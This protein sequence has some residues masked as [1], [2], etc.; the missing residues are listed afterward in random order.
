MKTIFL[1]PSWKHNLSVSDLTRYPPK[2]YSFTVDN[3]RERTLFQL[4]SKVNWTYSLQDLV[5]RKLPLMLIKSYLEKVRKIPQGTDLTYA[6]IHLVL[7]R[8]PWILDMQCEPPHLLLGNGWTEKQMSSYRDMVRT[9]LTSSDCKKII[10]WLEAG[11]KA[12]V[13][14]LGDEL[15]EKIEVVYWGVPGKSFVKNYDDRKIKLLFVNSGNINTAT[16]FNIKGGSEVLKAFVELDKR[17]N[18]LELVIRSGLPESIRRQY[19]NCSNIRIMSKPVPW[20]ELEYEW[21]TADIFV[22]PTR[23]P[24]AKVFLDAMCYELPIVTTDVWGNHEL[25]SDG[26]TGL[27]VHYSEAFKYIKNNM[28][29]FHSGYRDVLRKPDSELV[30]GMVDK[31]DVLI[32]NRELRR[33]LGKAG[34]REI[35]TGKFS[36]LKRNENL[37]KIFDEATS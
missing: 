29:Y 8:E 25:V 15:G 10:C 22:F 3:G 17:Y 2:G 7:R 23:V 36:L 31:I 32:Q 33:S 12:L 34:R 28:L 13:S 14:W 30:D 11:K 27:L 26:K 16:H 1:E 19:E 4:A 18:N 20:E 21:K 6:S 5:G 37:K 35:E 24:P 9:I